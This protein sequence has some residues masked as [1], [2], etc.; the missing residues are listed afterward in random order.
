MHDFQQ[1]LN[2]I[3]TQE[4]AMIQHVE[5]WSNINSSS[6]NL[7]GLTYLLSKLQKDFSEL[8]GEMALH[9]LPPH[10]KID[11]YGVQVAMPLGQALTIRKRPSAPIQVLLGGHF[12]TVY[13]LSSPFQQ[14]KR[15]DAQTLKGPGVSDMKGGLAIMLTSLQALERSPYAD[16]IGWE[17]ILNPDE[18]IGSP[19]S[20]YLFQAAAHRHQIGLI[21]EGSYSSGSFVSQRKGSANYTLIAKGQAAH[22]GRDFHLGKSAIYALS[23]VIYELEKLN[24][25]PGVTVNVG[26]MEGGG[27]TNI[28]PSLALC[29]LNMR[30]VQNEELLEAKHAFYQIVNQCRS[31]DGIQLEI[32]EESFRPSKI[33]DAATQQ[34]FSLYQQ[35]T[36]HL[37]QPFTLTESGGVCDGNTLAAEGLPTLDSAGAIGGKIHTEEE[38]LI[39]PSLVERAQLATLFL[40]K[41]ATQELRFVKEKNYA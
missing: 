16:A 12:D 21:F 40:L 28:V 14:V 26:W 7:Q 5:E 34:L 37:H 31:R 3:Q 36:E 22:A 17:I 38:Y 35:C 25:R 24:Q 33:F 18:E 27:P 6:D 1:Y 30:A 9:S 13:P 29:R 15:I 8:D 39:I 23:Q 32:I 10:V 11:S 4:A 20:S 2:W 19:G 41:L